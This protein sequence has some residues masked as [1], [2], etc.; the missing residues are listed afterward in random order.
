M[1]SVRLLVVLGSALV[2]ALGFGGAAQAAPVHFDFVGPCMGA[3]TGGGETLAPSSCNAY[4]LDEGDPVS[5]TLTIDSAY[6]AG[7]TSVRVDDK[8]GTA[9]SFTFGNQSWDL[10]DLDD[11]FI[12]VTFNADATQLVCFSGAAGCPSNDFTGFRNGDDVP[13]MVFPDSVE[14]GGKVAIPKASLTGATANG[15]PLQR[16]ASAPGQWVRR[17]P[18]NPIP[19]PSAALLFV[20]GGIVVQ[21]ARKHAR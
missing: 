14:V 13:L 20:M 17:D 4:G 11:P 6:V 7:D 18:S 2:L 12:E 10:S 5:G 19:E 1:R 9:F 15:V 8:A 3:G 16:I 21:M